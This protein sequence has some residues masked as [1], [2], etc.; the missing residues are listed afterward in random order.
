MGA[1]RSDGG[2][3]RAES[4]PAVIIRR[5][6]I[7]RSKEGNND[8]TTISE[9]DWK[10]YKRL[11]DV[12]LQRYCER[13]LSDA[14]GV[15]TDSSGSPHDRYLKLYDLMKERDKELGRTFDHFRRSSALMQLCG[16]RAMELLTEEEM[17]EFSQEARNF[18]HALLTGDW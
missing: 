1:L 4:V 12:A 2:S 15:I 13:A 18:V 3:E 14:Q 10:V 9:R 16:M 7:V 11:Y 17:A 6:R 5:T 8:V